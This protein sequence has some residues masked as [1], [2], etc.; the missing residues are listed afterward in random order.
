LFCASNEVPGLDGWTTD[1]SV[2]IIDTRVKDL[3][4]H[5]GGVGLGSPAGTIKG[6]ATGHCASRVP[7]TASGPH[8]PPGFANPLGSPCVRR[9][10]TG[11]T[12]NAGSATA[13][14]GPALPKAAG[15]RG[16]AEDPRWGAAPAMLS[17][18]CCRSASFSWWDL[19][20]EPGY[21]I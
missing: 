15:W 9:A 5:G 6:A 10:V 11:P 4:R 16:P 12:V 21:A 8:A 2:N 17:A 7:K 3:R 20:Q 18:T 13:G 14:R 1:S 19:K